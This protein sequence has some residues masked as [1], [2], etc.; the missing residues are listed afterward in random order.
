MIWPSGQSS[1]QANHTMASCTPVIMEASGCTTLLSLTL[2]DMIT[3]N[4]CCGSVLSTACM[5]KAPGHRNWTPA[6][7]AVSGP[8]EPDMGG[9]RQALLPRRTAVCQHPGQDKRQA[10]WAQQVWRPGQ[11]HTAISVVT[12]RERAPWRRLWKALRQMQ[13]GQTPSPAGT[14]PAVTEAYVGPAGDTL[15]T[16]GQMQP[17]GK[18]WHS[19]SLHLC[20]QKQ[21]TLEETQA[22]LQQ[23]QQESRGLQQQVQ[24]LQDRLATAAAA[25]SAEAGL[26]Q[27]VQQ[28]LAALDRRQQGEALQQM[29]HQV[30]CCAGAALPPLQPRLCCW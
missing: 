18:V 22:A 27:E 10:A 6:A 28:G 9:P 1:T 5:G 16:A 24:Q 12:A 11:T 14:P 21:G 8:M 13:L 20:L 25:F 15:P 3:C 26:S 7:G 17:L 29:R 2:C 30:G 4:C 19:H 23:V